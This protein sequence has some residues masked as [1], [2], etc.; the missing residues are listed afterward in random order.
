MGDYLSDSMKRGF[1]FFSVLLC[2]C[3][4]PASFMNQLEGTWCGPSSGEAE[5][6]E[7]WK[8]A[9][10]GWEGMGEWIE[11]GQKSLTERM[12]VT[13][14][15][16]G[17]YYQAHPSMAKNPTCFEV[18]SWDASSMLVSN[19]QHDFP[20][21]ILY[22]LSHDTLFIHLEGQDMNEESTEEDYFLVRSR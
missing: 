11:E 17:W 18:K 5:I 16:S 19:P 4:T 12:M 10:Q 1:W 9:D 7:T 2:S 21:N 6:C 13:E 8:A 22:R 3:T 14:T 15:D 20:R